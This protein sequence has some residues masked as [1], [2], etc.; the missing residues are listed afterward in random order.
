[1]F[2]V[3]EST[4]R[5]RTRGNV[6]PMAKVGKEPLLNERE[7]KDFVDHLIYMANIG[8]G[9]TKS[10]IQT[11]AK[12]YALSLKKTLTKKLEGSNKLSNNWFYHFMN[13]WPQLKLVKPQK[14][15]VHRS[16]ST[17]QEKIKKYFEELSTIMV[18]NNLL[19]KPNRIFNIDETGITSDHAPPKIVC[20]RDTKAQAVTSPRSSTITVIAAGNAIGNHIPPYFI[21]LGKRWM[22]AFLEGAPPGASGEMSESG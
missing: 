7:E 16:K 3:P 14:L 15:S 9:Y 17:S 2:Q 1:M 6:D 19:D 18:A 13:R 10:N 4:L 12:E 11:M 8:Y 20:N 22:P 5:D 21:F